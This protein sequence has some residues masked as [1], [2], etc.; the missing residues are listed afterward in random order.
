MFDPSRTN[1][2]PFPI[3]PITVFCTNFTHASLLFSDATSPNLELN[4]WRFLAHISGALSYLHA[5]NFLHQDL[6]PDN[7]LSVRKWCPVAQDYRTDWKLSD[8]SLNKF[9]KQT[10]LNRFH[11]HVSGGG[12]VPRIQIKI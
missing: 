3:F 10:A 1:R 12:Q 6:N 4:V 11:R 7:I 8:Y 5:S 2:S 9:L